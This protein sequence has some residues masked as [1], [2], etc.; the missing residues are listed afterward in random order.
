MS[1]ADPSRSKQRF[2]EISPRAWEHPDEASAR[3]ALEAIPGIN[4]LLQNML[5]A[6]SDP[7]FRLIYLA[8]ALRASERQFPQVHRLVHEA[9]HILDAPHVPEVYVAQTP[10]FNAGTIGIERPFIVLNAAVLDTLTEEELLCAIG[11]ELSHCLSGY[12]LYKTLLQV[13]LKLSVAAWQIPLG[14]VALFPAIVALMEWNRKSELS[15]DRAALLVVQEPAVLYSWLM[16]LAGGPQAAQMDVN[17]FFVQAAEYEGAGNPLT[18]LHKLLNLIL[19]SHPFPVIRLTELQ[20][21]VNSGA[22]AAIL[23]QTF[24]AREAHGQPIMEQVMSQLKAASETYQDQWETSKETVTN[25][26]TEVFSNLDTWLHQAFQ[27]VGSLLDFGPKPDTP[28]APTQ[29]A[30]PTPAH[31]QAEIFAALERLR[32]LQEKGIITAEEFEAQKAKL[33]SRL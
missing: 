20:A 2:P 23:A 27:G 18:H 1:S 5:G 16:K 24:P 22:Y 30:A 32:D 14:G 13:L 25:L 29:T 4:I 9:C 26:M 17:A 12:A 15:A 21:W 33:L 8:S 7:A 19:V 6:T 3:A 28:S 10:F 11:H 31:A